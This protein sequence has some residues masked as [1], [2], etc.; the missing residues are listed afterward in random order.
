MMFEL[1]CDTCDYADAVPVERSA[2][3]DARDHEAE[4]PTHNVLITE[5]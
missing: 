2:Y 1:S 5:Q 3:S 4:H